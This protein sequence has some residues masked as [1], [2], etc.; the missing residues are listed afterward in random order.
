M[1]VSIASALSSK[2]NCPNIGVSL[3]IGGL[4]EYPG[5]FGSD[6]VILMI[7]NYIVVGAGISGI[8]FSHLIKKVSPSVKLLI[9]ESSDSFGGRILKDPKTGANM[10]AKFVHDDFFVSLKKVKNIV[11]VSL[12]H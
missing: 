1:F 10:G 9:I 8:Y 7:Y 4:F 2:A 11:A 12:D 6:L 5:C 3:A